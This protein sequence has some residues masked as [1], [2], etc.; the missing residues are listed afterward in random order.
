MMITPSLVTVLF[1]SL[2]SQF[3]PCS[4]AISTITEPVFIPFT[5]SAV[6]SIGAF[7][8]GIS[9]V[10]IT[11]SASR[12]C[13]VMSS[14][15]FL[16]KSEDTSFTYPPSVLILSS[17]FNSMN[18]A[19]NDST[20]SLVSGR[21]S[22]TSTIAP[23]RFAVAIACNPATPAPMITIRAGLTVPAA[24]I[25]NGKILPKALAASNTVL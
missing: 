3:P 18:L 9:A 20:C 7:F 2:S 13:L 4:T 25:N 15:C 5:I 8:P 19:P 12:T 23:N 14:C 1:N 24:V 10:V 22:L 16:R 6:S 11:I 21:M 17:P